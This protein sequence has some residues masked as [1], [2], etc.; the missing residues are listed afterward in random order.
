[1]QNSN[2]LRPWNFILSCIQELR[3]VVLLYVV[4][5]EGSSP[6]RQGFCMAASESESCGTIGGG[7]MEYKLVELC[8]DMM[9]QEDEQIR[10]VTQYHDKTHTTDQS[11]MICSGM[12]RVV[13]IPI[14]QAHQGFIEDCMNAIIDDKPIRIEITPVGI[15]LDENSKVQD[16]LLFVSEKSWQYHEI[17]GIR[18]KLH[19]VGAGH[20][21]LALSELM[22]RLGFYVVLYD[23]RPDLNTFLENSWAD[24]KHVVDYEEIGSVILNS[25]QDYIVIMT[26][27]YRSD[28]IVLR[29]LIDTRY[30]YLGMLGSEAKI[31][32]LVEELCNEGCTNAQLSKINAPIGVQIF[33]QTAYEIAVSIAAEIIQIKNT[34][35]AQRKTIDN[36]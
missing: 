8:R 10:L 23:D 12:Q 24:E 28:K 15:K 32:R 3:P 30:M 34:G 29:Q 31:R 11:G 26:I 18:F 4:E 14:Q 20:V 33:S 25:S 6:G 35:S 21:S 7:I 27:G 16:G 2:A 17:I 13:I 1:M 9:K 22:S 19:V 36:L 5:S